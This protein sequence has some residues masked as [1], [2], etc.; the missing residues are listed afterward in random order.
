MSTVRA[1][2]SVAAIL[3]AGSYAIPISNSFRKIIVE[4]FPVCRGLAQAADPDEAAFLL[5]TEAAMTKMM[6][7]MTIAPTNDVDR[8]FVERMVAHHQGAIEM[9]EAQLRY[10][11][12]KQLERLA[13]EIIVTQ[14]Q[15]IA[16]M[17]LAPGLPL[18]SS[19]SSPDQLRSEKK[20]YSTSAHPAA[21]TIAQGALK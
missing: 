2:I 6:S 5:E 13:Q 17:R 4:T 19:V 1:G 15:E 16:A 14:Q 8:D 9:A 11:R 10:G 12:N 7:A 3:V 18:L 20:P 21:D